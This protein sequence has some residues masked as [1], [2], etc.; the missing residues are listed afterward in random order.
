MAPTNDITFGGLGFNRADHLR[1]DK[2]ALLAGREVAQSCILWR[3]RPLVD[4]QSGTLVMVAMDHPAIASATEIFLGVSE[5]HHIYAADISSWEPA[6][7]Q[8]PSDTPL[9][10]ESHQPHPDFSEHQAFYDLRNIMVQLSVRDAQLAATAKALFAWHRSHRFCA[11]CGNPSEM[12]KSG[13]QRDCPT[14]GTPH[15]PRTDPVVIML[16]ERGNE[17]LLGRA[18]NWPEGMYSCLAGFME[19]GETIEMAVAREVMEETNIAVQNVRYVTSQPWAFP[20]NLMIGCRCDALAG[21]I[22]IDPIELQDAQWVSKETLVKAF[23]GKDVGILPARAGSIASYL[24]EN[25]L[26]DT[27]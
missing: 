17:I 2:D 8:T 20:S 4:I 12:A 23:A 7:I 14:C 10:D 25:W 21:E 27:I 3:G 18:P 5:A 22:N 6:E 19:P 16:V 24:I 15:F 13:W 26:K 9:F 11:A 1:G